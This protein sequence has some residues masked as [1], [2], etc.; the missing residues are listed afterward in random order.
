MPKLARDYR[1]AENDLAAMPVRVETWRTG[2]GV[3]YN[4]V[5]I[6]WGGRR[7]TDRLEIRFGKGPWGPVE[8]YEHRTNRT[9][10]L[11]SHRWQPEPGRYDISL[12][13]DDPA[14]PTRRLD[15]GD[16]MRTVEVPYT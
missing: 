2:G 14:I 1:P 10:S 6:I 11:W 5:G 9:W 8:R 15:R 12:R 4:L 16:Y 7:T 3:S 13:V